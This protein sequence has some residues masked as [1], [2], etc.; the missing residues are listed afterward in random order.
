[1]MLSHP[2]QTILAEDYAP[3]RRF[4]KMILDDQ[5]YQVLE[6]DHEFLAARGHQQLVTLG[7][8]TR[9]LE[10]PFPIAAFTQTV[11]EMWTA[12]AAQRRFR[13]ARSG[14]AAGQGRP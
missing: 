3:I 6:A 8:D 1:M 2:S 14:V 4:V 9:F 10:K 7:G 5:G 12:R 11:N 13:S